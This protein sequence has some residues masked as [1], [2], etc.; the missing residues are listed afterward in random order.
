MDEALNIEYD[1]VKELYAAVLDQALLDLKMLNN[2]IKGN[3]YAFCNSAIANRNWK[4]LTKWFEKKNSLEPFTFECI[5]SVLELNSD[6]VRKRIQPL[7]FKE[8]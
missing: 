5:C 3:Q 2:P 7:F 1:K 8:S 4:I 6:A